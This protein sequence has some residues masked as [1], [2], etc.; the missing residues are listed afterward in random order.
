MA[1]G[2]VDAEISVPFKQSASR[3]TYDQ[4]SPTSTPGVSMTFRSPPAKR[5]LDDDV[6]AN[7]KAG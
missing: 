5:M 3:Q 1:I 4:L 7:T 2:G 6:R